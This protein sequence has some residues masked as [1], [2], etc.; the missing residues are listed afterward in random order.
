M[1]HSTQWSLALQKDL[2]DFEVQ[3]GLAVGCQELDYSSGWSDFMRMSIYGGN[4]DVSE[5]G[6][7]W[8]ND[9]ASMNTL[10]PFSATEVRAVGGAE[11]Y[12]PGV[13]KSGTS[14][15]VV[16]AI[17]WLTDISL[18]CYRR[19]LLAKAGVKEENAFATPAQF[20]QTLQQ[21]QDAGIE[22]PWVV[23]TQ[24]SYINVHNLA[25]WV[26]QAGE[27][28]VDTQNKLVLLDR[29]TVRAAII[30]YFRLH[31]YLSKEMQ[32]LSERD[33]DGAFV[34]GRAAVN[35][36]G[37]WSIIAA[38]GQASTAAEN[39]GLAVPLGCSYT[40]G[41]SLIVWQKTAQA[42]AALELI[43]HLTSREFQVLFPKTIG[44]LP[45]RLDSLESFPLPDPALYPVVLQ[46]LKTG[47]SLP[48]LGLW[49]LIEDRLAHA[50]PHLW[51]DILANPEPDLD[52]LYDK[53]I[54]PLANR[55]NITMSQS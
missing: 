11:A 28:L 7:T 48:N 49:G 46:A 55:L 26:W 12:V 21:L 38:M 29:P 10:R 27:D 51:D 14:T 3:Y 30:S 1:S 15:G 41:S 35:I 4:P 19:D 23:P 17:P 18:V 37:P 20:E 8:V 44:L 40:G 13:W 50:I 31:K 16:W 5:I 53:H 33:A 22:S 42:A 2:N 47:R 52:A 39:L 34:N 54:I 36:S 32:H 43:S 24:R 6:T 45:A 9:F 25:M